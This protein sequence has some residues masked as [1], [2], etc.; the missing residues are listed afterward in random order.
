MPHV[1]GGKALPGLR[2]DSVF[3][4]RKWNERTR[5]LFLPF[6]GEGARKSQFE[7][8]LSDIG[9]A[10][11]AE[12]VHPGLVA[13]F[14][15]QLRSLAQIQNHRRVLLISEDVLSDS[16]PAASTLGAVVALNCQQPGNRF[17]AVA[18]DDI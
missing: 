12:S 17:G 18:G 5:R 16:L 9:Q 11:I 2:A 6:I 4:R 1:I 3:I 7:R 10:W 8:V 15:E 13:K 14:L